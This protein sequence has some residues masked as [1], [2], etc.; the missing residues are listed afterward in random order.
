MVSANVWAAPSV[1]L[2]VVDVNGN[3]SVFGPNQK[4]RITIG[5]TGLAQDPDGPYSYT[6]K[7]NDNSIIGEGPH[8]INKN[9][10]KTHEWDGAGFSDGTYTIRFEVTE[11]DD[12]GQLRIFETPLSREASATFDKTKPEISIGTDIVEFSPNR[13]RVLDTIDV[14]L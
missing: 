12:G 1:K 10:T 3:D 14:F 2:S 13:D 6:L 4:L 8:K 7:V 11:V 9:Q 5:V